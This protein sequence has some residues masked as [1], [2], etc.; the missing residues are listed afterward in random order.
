MEF[1]DPET[2]D[3]SVESDV[4]QRQP[5]FSPLLWRT[6]LVSRS[7]HTERLASCLLDWLTCWLP[8]WLEHQRTARVVV[9]FS[10]HWLADWLAVWLNGWLTDSLCNSCV[11]AVIL[12]C[13]LLFTKYWLDLVELPNHKWQFQIQRKIE[14]SDNHG[15]AVP[16]P[17][18]V[19]VN[20]KSV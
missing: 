1:V 14:P 15:V 2:P 11:F 16:S 12:V 8:G 20:R 17:L 7:A 19:A 10:T 9:H 6:D 13:S 3:N 4:T 18:F 5:F